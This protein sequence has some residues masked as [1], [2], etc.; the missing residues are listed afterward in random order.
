MFADEEQRAVVRM[1]AAIRELK[2]AN[3]N[4]AQTFQDMSLKVIKSG[5]SEAVFIFAEIFP[6]CEFKQQLLD[7]AEKIIQN[8]CQLGKKTGE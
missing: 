6:D 4:L 3:A 1:F 2:A 7:A 5:D 8:K